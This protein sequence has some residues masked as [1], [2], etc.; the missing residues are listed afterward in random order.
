MLRSASFLK[1][2][3]VILV[4]FIVSISLV[5]NASAG[6]V[7]GSSGT[8]NIIGNDPA[9]NTG[10]YKIH[11][12][13]SI[14]D[15]TSSNDP[16][17]LTSN[18]QL[19][20]T[21][22]NLGVDSTGETPALSIGRFLVFAPSGSGTSVAFYKSISAVGSGTAP[23]T[24]GMKIKA[25]PANEGFWAFEDSQQNPLF[26]D[27]LTSQTLVLTA[28]PGSLNNKSVILEI[29][30]TNT[31]PSI[32]SDVTVTLVPEPA[33]MVLFGVA[34]LLSLRRRRKI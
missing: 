17:G 16:L 10:S 9:H 4:V 28:V 26:A 8:V 12:V 13:Y 29:D 2:T 34:S 21:I 22:T 15:G 20:F 25:N 14:Y 27:G 19:A 7:A 1:C 30:T 3:L 11:V 33:S 24:G 5:S 23:M 32:S 6:P 18:L 31:N